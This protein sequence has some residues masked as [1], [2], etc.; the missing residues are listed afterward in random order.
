MSRDALAGYGFALVSAV[1]L[2]GY[3][4]V[5][6]TPGELAAFRR[7]AKRTEHL[8]LIPHHISTAYPVLDRKLPKSLL[9]PRYKEF[10]SDEWVDP[11]TGKPYRYGRID[12]KRYWLEADFELDSGGLERRGISLPGPDWKYQLGAHR[13]EFDIREEPP[14][15]SYYRN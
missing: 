6:G 8:T 14:I 3:L 10:F 1:L 15:L 9:D 11:S 4:R 2:W 12:D 7:D 5:V 13:I